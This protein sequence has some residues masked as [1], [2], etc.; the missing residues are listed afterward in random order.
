MNK[1]PHL[2]KAYEYPQKSKI[3]ISHVLCRQVFE[4]KITIIDQGRPALIRK[5]TE[6]NIWY[7][8]PSEAGHVSSPSKMVSNLLTKNSFISII[9]TIFVD[10]STEISSQ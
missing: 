9:G 7:E 6:P 1:L 8:G 3:Y 10:R 5:L 4:W 2:I